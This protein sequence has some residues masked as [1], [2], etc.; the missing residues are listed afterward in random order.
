MIE[1]G[2][3]ERFPCDAVFGVHNHPGAEP[4]VLLFRKG[5]SCRR[6][7]RRSSPIEG[8]GGHAARPHLTVDPVVIAA[9][10]VMALQTIVAR[11]VDPSQPAVVTVGSIHAGTANNVIASTAEAGTERAFVQRRSARC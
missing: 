7:T 2:L 3:F 5:R 9:S 4:G 6:A 11:N 1:D 10:I 8:V